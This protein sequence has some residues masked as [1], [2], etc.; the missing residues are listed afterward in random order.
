MSKRRKGTGCLVKRGGTWYMKITVEG[1]PVVRTTGT[2]SKVEA[3]RM[4][5]EFARPFQAKSTAEK[6]E[7]IESRI[8][9]VEEDAPEDG[10]ADTPLDDVLDAY[11]GLANSKKVAPSTRVN[12]DSMLNGMTAFAEG[13]QRP[14]QRVRDVDARFASDFMAGLKN[15]SA[16]YYNGVLAL[17]RSVW[18]EFAAVSKARCFRENPWKVLKYR[19]ADP[20]AKR[21][22]T[23][24]ELR[25]V[26]SAIKDEDT[27]L[28]FKT[29][30]YTGMRIGDCAALSWKDV[31]LERGVLNVKPIKTRRYG[32]KV[33]IPLHPALRSEL[34]KR[35]SREGYV[36]PVNAKS[37]RNRT[38]AER[39]RNV[40]ERAGLTRWT[41]E[42]GRRRCEVS[43][44]SLRHTFVS[45]AVEAGV[46]LELVRRIT[47]HATSEMTVRYAHPSDESLK[48]AV[49]AVPALGEAP[50][51]VRVEIPSDLAERLSRLGASVEDALRSYL[52]SRA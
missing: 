39:F 33:T 42:S 32:T 8:R 9:A 51:T 36:S 52:D 50:K 44:H 10:L 1:R 46:P 24:A 23:D 17:F 20:P 15:G 2:S 13:Y 25:A 43:F 18:T 14:V 48:A 27:M 38:I 40:L 34:E 11:Y 41:E 4:L 16:A 19:P 45:R 31:D 6:L 5:D 7:N 12:Y 49:D 47:G 29:G 30:L 22:L 21:P 35:P 28:L 37:Y 3:R 26:E